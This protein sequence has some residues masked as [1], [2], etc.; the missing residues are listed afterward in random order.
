MKMFNKKPM[1]EV[2]KK[3]EAISFS[4]E[5]EWQPNF[6]SYKRT[7]KWQFTCECNEENE[8]RHIRIDSF[9]KN[10]METVDS[11]AHYHQKGF[12][13]WDDFMNMMVRFRKVVYGW[14]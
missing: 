4:L 6:E 1:C 5:S 8:Q 2:C 9:F 11:L 13:N 3:N 12:V 7:G 14:K 10:P